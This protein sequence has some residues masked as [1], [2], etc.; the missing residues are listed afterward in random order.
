[1]KA[2]T[3]AAFHL[4]RFNS[5]ST[6][7]VTSGLSKAAAIAFIALIFATTYGHKA[8]TKRYT[9]SVKGTEPHLQLA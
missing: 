2:R 5:P 9:G 6:Q 4:F 8:I 1:V 7:Y 3:K